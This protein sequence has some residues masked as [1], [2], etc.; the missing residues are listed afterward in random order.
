M[1]ADRCVNPTDPFYSTPRST[2]PASSRTLL[3]ASGFSRWPRRITSLTALFFKTAT[4]G[5]WV[6]PQGFLDPERKEQPWT[7]CLLFESP[8]VSKRKFS[9]VISTDRPR[10]RPIPPLPKIPSGAAA[11][12]SRLFF[13]AHASPGVGVP[14]LPTLPPA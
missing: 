7:R 10:A 5:K 8:R 6:N 12:R 2:R 13:R 1:T 3:L 11:V 14:P 9:N 4:G